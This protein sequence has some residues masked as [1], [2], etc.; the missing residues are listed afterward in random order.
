MRHFSDEKMMLLNACFLKEVIHTKSVANPILVHKKNMK[1][2]CVCVDCTVLNKSCPKNPF[3]LPCIDQVIDLMAGS[4]LLCFLDAY[5]G[6]HQ[7]KM[8]ESD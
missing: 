8:K 2:L 5:S 4:K 6:Y 3:H 7:I 1:I